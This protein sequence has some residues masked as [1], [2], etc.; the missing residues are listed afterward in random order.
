MRLKTTLFLSLGLLLSAPAWSPT[1]AAAQ[2]EFDDFDDDFAEPEPEPDPEPEPEP[3]PADEGDEFADLEDEAFAEDELD[4]EEPALED[5]DLE[6]GDFE[7]A[8]VP[9]DHSEEEEDEPRTPTEEQQAY[10]ER[11]HIMHNTWN[12]SVGGIHVVDAASGAPGAFRAQL[13]LDF[14]FVDGWLTLPDAP[15]GASNSHSHIGGSL[16]LSWT[17]FEFLEIYASLASWA[18]SNE[19]ENPNLFQVLGDTLFGVKAWYQVEGAEFLYLGGDIGLGFLN[20]VGDIGLVGESTSFGIR[21][22]VTADLRELED[23]VPFIARLNLQYWFDNSQALVDDVEAARYAALPDPRPCPMGDVEGDCMEDRHLVTRVERYSLQIDRVDRFRIALGLEAPLR[24][25]EDFYINPLAEWVLDIPVN[26]QG[27]SCLYIPGVGT[28][29]PAAGQDGCLDRQGASAFEQTLTLGV[30]VMPPLR[31]LEIFAAVDI[32]LTGV[33]T[34]V[35]ELS[36]QEPYDVRLGFGYAFDTVPQIEEVEREVVREVV[37]EAEPPPMGRI[38]GTVV[39]QED[40]SPAAGAVVSFPER[41]LTSLAAGDAGGFTTYELEPGEVEMAITHPEF[42]D[43]SCTG[44]IPEEGGDVEVRCELEA[45]PRVGSVRGRVIGEGGSGVGGAQVTL[46][47]PESRTLT[48]G[49]DG[50]FAAQDLPPGTYTA[51]VEAENYLIKQETFDVAA[52]EQAEPTITLIARPRRSLVRVRR[53]Q[54]VIRRQVNFATDSAEILP[55]STE[56]LSEV[57]DVI[58]RHP[59]LTEIEIQ[60]HTDNRGGRQHNQ[61]LSQRR[62]EAVRDWLVRAGV[63]ASRLEARGYGQENP[64]VPNITAAN[65]ARNRRVQF[66][67][68]E[69][70]EPEE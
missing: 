39:D 34:F 21:G 28:D 41:E 8:E 59:E 12:G 4:E 13:G 63:D 37:R 56:L 7:D 14:F 70:A 19:Q 42:H 27:Y 67:I 44:T 43:G 25:M 33:N 65:R 18:N 64:L 32:G 54:I 3:E 20:T 1:I 23:A 48:T 47:G 69:Q 29:E 49:P 26:R 55:S 53:R 24:V 38:V 60:G 45:L 16:S 30:R 50:V 57:A 52:R 6:A 36:G 15:A 68:R 31:G 40:G 35:R 61:E 10:R 2:D 51:R 46:G 62:A 17:P 58:M 9:P 5:G 66:V 11:R 22:N